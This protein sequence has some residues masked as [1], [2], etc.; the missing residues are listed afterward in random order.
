MLYTLAPK[1]APHHRR[2]RRSRC[3]L[4]AR[5]PASVNSVHAGPAGALP[6]AQ[7]CLPLPHHS[8]RLGR[9]VRT[10]GLA[11]DWVASVALWAVDR[12][13]LVCTFALIPRPVPTGRPSARQRRLPRKRQ[14]PAQQRQQQQQQARPPQLMAGLRQARRTK[15]PSPKPSGRQPSPRHQPALPGMPACGRRRW[16]MTPRRAAS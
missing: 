9:H 15:Q 10:R 12:L 14:Q 4:Q 3:C 2:R 5:S 6:P 11:G 7:A 8:H 16:L 1:P 13:A